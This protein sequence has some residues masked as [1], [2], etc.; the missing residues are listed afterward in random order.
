MTRRDGDVEFQEVRAAVKAAVLGFLEALAEFE[1]MRHREP[2]RRTSSWSVR[3]KGGVAP[4][5]YGAS[6]DARRRG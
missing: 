6:D 5:R 3:R 4:V 1:V 2:D